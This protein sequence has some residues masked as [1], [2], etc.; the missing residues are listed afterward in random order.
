MPI[1]VAVQDID[2][3]KVLAALSFA[4]G[5]N[6]VKPFV[7]K[8]PGSGWVVGFKMSDGQLI[9]TGFD[10]QAAADEW[11]DR[12]IALANQGAPRQLN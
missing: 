1:I 7:A 5:G 10:T 12:V 2:E 11:L 6:R 8:E 4:D 3:H 9:V